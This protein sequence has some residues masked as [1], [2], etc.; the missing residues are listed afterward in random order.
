MSKI[1][2]LKIMRNQ[3]LV[4]DLNIIKRLSKKYDRENW[5]FRSFLKMHD[6]S[7]SELDS[8]VDEINEQ[9]TKEIDCTKC[10]NCCKTTKPRFK[11][12]DLRKFKDQMKTSFHEFKRE[13]LIANEEERSSFVF[14][15]LPCQF[16]ENNKCM[17]YDARPKDCKSFPHLH[18][19][20]FRT[21]L[22]GVVDNTSMCP[23]VFNVYEIL[24]EKL[25][26]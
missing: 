6:M 9:V 15:S 20:E 18:K 11:D 10:G 1:G 25:W 12:A 7:S 14:K 3:G 19:K 21:R 13:H 26:H 17:N 8:I 4:T 24:K 16:L 5:E 22:W 23:I 2:V